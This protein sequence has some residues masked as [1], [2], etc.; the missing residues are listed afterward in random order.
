VKIQASEY[1]KATS[2][3]DGTVH[4]HQCVFATRVGNLG[5]L[6]PNCENLAFSERVWPQI[7][8]PAFC[9]YFYFALICVWRYIPEFKHSLSP[10][11]LSQTRFTDWRLKLSGPKMEISIDRTSTLQF[12][13]WKPHMAGLCNSESTKGQII[14]INLPRAA[15]S[16]SFRCRDFVVAWKKLLNDNYLF[17]VELLQHFLQL[18]KL[19]HRAACGPRAVCCAGL[20]YGNAGQTAARRHFVR[21]S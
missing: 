3:H 17:E 13:S 9:E 14:N 8:C 11:T 10:C 7:L 12:I 4:R 6:R 15:K 18:R 16:I 21:L 5:L 2:S 19:S 20:T 1:R